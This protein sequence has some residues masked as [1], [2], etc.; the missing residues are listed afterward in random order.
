[1]FSAGHVKSRKLKKKKRNQHFHV[2]TKKEAESFS[3]Q[4][5]LLIHASMQVI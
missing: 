2:R 4:T 1:M 3:S 5:A